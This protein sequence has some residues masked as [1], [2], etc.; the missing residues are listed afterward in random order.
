MLCAP[1]ALAQS[2][3]AKHVK[4]KLKTLNPTRHD[5]CTFPPLTMKS[6]VPIWSIVPSR[7]PSVWIAS[8][9]LEAASF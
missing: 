7:R 4:R 8:T 2:P 6:T 1:V 9:I 5:G 3:K